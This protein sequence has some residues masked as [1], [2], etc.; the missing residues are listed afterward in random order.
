MYYHSTVEIQLQAKGWVPTLLGRRRRLH[1]LM[2]KNY[3]QALR[4][5]IN[6]TI[7]GSAA[8]IVKVAMRNFDREK[9]K[10]CLS[11]PRWFGVKLLIQVHDELMVE[12]PDEVIDE[13]L[14]VLK[15]SM[16]N[17]VKLSLPLVASP[18]TGNNW[19]ECK[20]D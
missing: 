11:D 1:E 19:D 17:A 2:E 14:A 16:E 4:M 15:D 8:D 12:A 6:S 7:Q 20:G 10:H 9:K 13:A 18:N 5:A 3:N